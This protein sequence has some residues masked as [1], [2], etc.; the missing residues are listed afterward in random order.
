MKQH[1]G[2][3]ANDLTKQLPPR[4]RAR[5]IKA[6]DEALKEGQENHY[7]LK[8]DFVRNLVDAYSIGRK[9][10]AD[11]YWDLVP[12]SPGLQFERVLNPGY[13]ITY[14]PSAVKVKK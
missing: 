5:L 8:K 2:L 7:V 12:N 9:T 6:Q 1:I 4:L 11:F 10:L 13:A 14:L 3:V